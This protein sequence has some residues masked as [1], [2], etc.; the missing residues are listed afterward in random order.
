MKEDSRGI[1]KV[2]AKLGAEWIMKRVSL[3]SVPT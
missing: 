2:V 3:R 1:R